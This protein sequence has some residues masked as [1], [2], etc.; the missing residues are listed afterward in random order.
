MRTTREVRWPAQDHTAGKQYFLLVLL[1]SGTAR[2]I[3]TKPEPDP[4]PSFA[5]NF[6]IT[7]PVFFETVML[8]SPGWPRTHCVAQAGLSLYSC[9]L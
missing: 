1:Q 9:I 4:I 6:T 7:I 3:Q 8:Y 2:M 5:R